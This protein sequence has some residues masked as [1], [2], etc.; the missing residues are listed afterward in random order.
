VHQLTCSYC[1]FWVPTFSNV[2]V[3]NTVNTDLVD[4]AITKRIEVFQ[5]VNLMLFDPR[6]SCVRAFSLNRLK[7]V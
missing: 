6:L 3:A 4:E 7:G 5:L 1:L 2:P